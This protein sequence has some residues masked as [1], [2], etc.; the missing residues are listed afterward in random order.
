[1]LYEP[2][3]AVRL[4][5]RVASLR[6][7]G[8]RRATGH[9]P[10]A[11]RAR[12][13][14]KTMN[15]ESVE[16][17]A[18]ATPRARR[19]AKREKTRDGDEEQAA[20]NRTAYTTPVAT[21]GGAE[22]TEWATASSDSASPRTPHVCNFANMLFRAWPEMSRDVE[23]RVEA[24]EALAATIER[25]EEEIQKLQEEERVTVTLVQVFAALAEHAGIF[26]ILRTP[27]DER[28][29]PHIT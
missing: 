8:A 17:E 11:L 24:F 26:D 20:E 29:S 21:R 9:R 12:S 25:I 15:I 23:K 7:C 5:G 28:A 10:F 1:M 6:L 14:D 19:S 27:Q 3:Q 13:M 16:S 2:E 4:A 18:V 22:R